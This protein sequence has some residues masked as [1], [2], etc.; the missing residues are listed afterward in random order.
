MGLVWAWSGPLRKLDA[1]VGVWFIHGDMVSL[2]GLFHSRLLVGCHVLFLLLIV[3]L[4]LNVM[5]ILM[6]EFIRMSMI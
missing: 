4:F 2:E 1:Y 5:I 6:M 3:F